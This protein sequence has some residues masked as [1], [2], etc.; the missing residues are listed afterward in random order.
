DLRR[1]PQQPEP[2]AVRPRRLYS[3]IDRG[4]TAGVDE[5]EAAEVDDD[6]LEPTV[7]RLPKPL[8]EG[9]DAGGV[10]FP[11]ELDDPLR[12]VIADADREGVT[13]PRLP[14]DCPR[15]RPRMPPAFR[16]CEVRSR[17]PAA[18][19]SRAMF[20]F[21]KG[22]SVGCRRPPVTNDTRPW[23]GDRNGTRQ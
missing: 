23:R 10:Q 6:G 3:S 4:D 5:I 7:H 16:S 8:D 14:T 20:A 22:P 13:F 21:L 12:A 9:V 1:P 19:A 2:G 17:P 11:E 15:L 18:N